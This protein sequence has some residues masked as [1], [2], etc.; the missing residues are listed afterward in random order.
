MEPHASATRAAS[1]KRE[2]VA[3]SAAR[4]RSLFQR[5]R[6]FG[7]LFCIHSRTASVAGRA[8]SREYQLSGCKTTSRKALS[9][10]TSACGEYQDAIAFFDR[11][12]ITEGMRLLLTQVAQRLSVPVLST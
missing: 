2:I 3:W 12:F 9:S 1:F 8:S 7:P 6:G 5:C 10:G 11:T 4:N